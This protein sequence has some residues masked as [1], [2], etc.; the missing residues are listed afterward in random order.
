[1]RQETLRRG[2]KSRCTGRQETLFRAALA[3]RCA[4][5]QETL[6]WVAGDTAVGGRSRC[7]GWQDPGGRSRRRA[8]RSWAAG[9]ADQGEWQEQPGGRS[10]CGGGKAGLQANFT[11][12]SLLGATFAG[13]RSPSCAGRQEPLRR[14][15]A[16]VLGWQETLLP[17][18]SAAALSDRSHCCGWKVPLRGMTG[19]VAVGSRS[20]CAGGK[21]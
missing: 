14:A 4:G 20:R 7:A 17:E 15:G 16:A 2:G 8:R 18:A 21:M 11:A 5:R 9:D 19:D 12:A 6:L 3:C 13:C 10:R 1:M